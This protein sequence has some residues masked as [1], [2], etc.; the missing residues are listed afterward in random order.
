[1]KTY[2]KPAASKLLMHFDKELK[3]VLMK[4][5]KSF[6]AKNPLL[7]SNKQA[8]IQQLSAA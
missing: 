3:N 7:M 2:N 4:D 8:A 1:M 5:L 6:R